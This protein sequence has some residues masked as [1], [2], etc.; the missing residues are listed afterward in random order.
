MTIKEIF[1]VFESHKET[2]ELL[3]LENNL[4]LEV[5]F[6]F[7]AMER[8]YQNYK[9]FTKALKNEYYEENYNEIINANFEKSGYGFENK[10][11]EID[12]NI[13]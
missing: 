11:L 7:S 5:V 6:K 4:T 9:A 3:G 1:K 12:I 8:N 10:E 2:S 13:Y